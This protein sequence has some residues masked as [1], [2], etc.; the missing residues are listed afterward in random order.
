MDK[1][2]V[3]AHRGAFFKVLAGT[4]R[5][6]VAVMT[7]APGGNSGAESGHNGDQLVMVLEGTAE[8]RVGGST[9]SASAGDVAIIPAH[10]QHQILN[11]SDAEVFLVSVY[12]PPA[13]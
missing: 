6:Q 3:F 2:N 8:L 12:A 13:Y 9:L 4:D 5:S 1:V 10:T 11:R 7:L